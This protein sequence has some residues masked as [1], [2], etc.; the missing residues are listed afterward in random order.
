MDFAKLSQQRYSVRAYRPEPIED[1]KLQQI[2]EA[3]RMA[4]TA[5]NR[6]PFQ[7]IVIHTAGRQDELKRLYH[8]DWFSQAPVI[9]GI[10]A[11][12]D[13]AW[14]RRDGK[15]YADV[16][17][18]I[19]MD[20]LIL[21]ATD[22]GLGTCWVAAFD[23]VSAREIL[24]LPDGVEPVAFTPVGYPADQPKSKQRKSLTELVRYEYW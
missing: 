13:G 4:P 6:Q 17:A 12:G 15:N 3:A 16:D 20:H 21:A 18:T 19:A 8:R 14:V 5:A 9:I 10:C 2:L 7:L 23:P 24:R 1:E 22:L 11:V